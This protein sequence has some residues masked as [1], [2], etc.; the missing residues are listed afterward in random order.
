MVKK[1]K[2]TNKNLK[3]TETGEGCSLYW[4]L[5]LKFSLYP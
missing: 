1:K 5:I 3:Q 2:Q 4:M